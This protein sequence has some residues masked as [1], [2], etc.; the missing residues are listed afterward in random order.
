MHKDDHPTKM[1][2][3]NCW[4]QNERCRTSFGWSSKIYAADIQV[5]NI[6]MSPTVV[7][8]EYEPWVYVT[9]QGYLHLFEVKKT[10]READS[11]SLFSIHT[12]IQYPR[13]IQVHRDGSND[14]TGAA[15]LVQDSVYQGTSWS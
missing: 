5:N 4:E 3:Q 11:S 2:L 14:P 1:V 12:I 13:H 15:F 6:K 7:I 9:P 8:R 10:E